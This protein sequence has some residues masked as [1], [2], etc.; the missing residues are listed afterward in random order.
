MFTQLAN[1]LIISY[2]F[3][4]DDFDLPPGPTAFDD[5]GSLY[6]DDYNNDEVWYIT[7]A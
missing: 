6:F 7:I 4:G 1:C 3:R 2:K 5:H